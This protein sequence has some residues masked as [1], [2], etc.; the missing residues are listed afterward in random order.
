MT[1]FSD[2]YW[3]ITD[4]IFD[5]TSSSGRESIPNSSISHTHIK[6]EETVASADE[7]VLNCS[8]TIQRIMIS[9]LLHSS[10][11]S[12][13][14]VQVSNWD[15]TFQVWLSL[16]NPNIL[17]GFDMKSIFSLMQKVT[18]V[19]TFQVVQVIKDAECQYVLTIYRC[20]QNWLSTQARQHHFHVIELCFQWLN[21]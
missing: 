12:P 4:S 17:N 15:L 9:F 1:Q 8:V 13:W 6:R 20:I 14:Q 18:Q 5:L 2:L 7:I 16:S 3:Q 10:I 21:C 11:T 19:C